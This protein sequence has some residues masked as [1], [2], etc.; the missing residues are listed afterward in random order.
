MNLE[1]LILKLGTMA[2]INI[3][4]IWYNEKVRNKFW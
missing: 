2:H 1:R 4:V 3:V